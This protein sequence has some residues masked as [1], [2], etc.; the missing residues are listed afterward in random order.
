MYP[1]HIFGTEIEL[2]QQ[3]LALLALI[4]IWIYRGR[5]GY[6]SRPFQYACYAFYPVHMLG[7]VLVLNFVNR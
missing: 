5:Q 6:H 2:C 7:L 4:P 3:S 1:I